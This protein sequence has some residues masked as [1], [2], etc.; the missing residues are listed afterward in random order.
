MY[1]GLLYFL[2]NVNRKQNQSMLSSSQ[3]LLDVSLLKSHSDSSPPLSGSTC[4]SNLDVEIFVGI[5]KIANHC[6]LASLDILTI[7]ACCVKVMNQ[8]SIA[9]VKS[10][11]FEGSA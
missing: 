11:L 1:G 3:T 5:S 6:G 10:D 9:K 8:G 2:G 7:P 4:S